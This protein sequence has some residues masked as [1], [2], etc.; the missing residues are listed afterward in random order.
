M[1]EPDASTP[2]AWERRAQSVHAD[3]RVYRILREHYVHPTDGRAGDFYIIDA[4]DWAVALALTTDDC[5]VCIN[6]FRFGSQA[7]S[8]EVPAG[9]VDPGEDAITA[10]RREL[11]E[12]TGYAGSAPQVLG[13]LQPNPAMQRN[14]CTFVL[15]R[16]ARK[17]GPPAWDE[18]EEIAVHEAPRDVVEKWIQ[19]GRMYHGIAVAALYYLGRAV[20]TWH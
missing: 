1:S 12:E 11:R 16:E 5:L 19:S 13:T 2:P 10:A 18:H 20:P 7:T 8:W 6:Q 4:R 14:R 15:F 9:C 3:C 17:V